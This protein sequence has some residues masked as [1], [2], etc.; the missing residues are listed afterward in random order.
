MICQQIRDTFTYPLV[1][2]LLACKGFPAR[3]SSPFKSVTLSLDTV[4]M[5]VLL[6][7]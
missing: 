3:H 1:L 7:G 5:T 2:R 4:I 6:I